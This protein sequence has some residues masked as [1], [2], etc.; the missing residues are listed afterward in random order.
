MLTVSS[1]RR[2]QD[3][4]LAGAFGQYNYLNDLHEGVVGS[5]RPPLRCL[6]LHALGTRK[7]FNLECPDK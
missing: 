1:L 6:A 4:P 3:A 5:L 2:K 7:S